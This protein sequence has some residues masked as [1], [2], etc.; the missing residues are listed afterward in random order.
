MG[1]ATLILDA[2][3]S[4]LRRAMGEIPGITQRAQAVMTSQAR[5]GGRERV[6]VDQTFAREHEAISMRLRRAR[7]KQEKDATAKAKEEERKRARDA[8]EFARVKDSIHTQLMRER[9]RRE[10]AATRTEAAEGR[11]RLAADVAFN[12]ERDRA[13]AAMV[14]DRQRRE[15]QATRERRAAEREGGQVVGRIGSAIGGAATGFATGMD[16]QVQSARQR[17]AAPER[18]VGNAIY[19]AGGDRSETAAAMR[20]ITEFAQANRIPAEEIAQ[21]LQGAQTE[22]SVLGSRGQGNAGTRDTALSAFLNTA[23]LAR[24]TGNDVGETTRLAG[25][26]ASQG[27]DPALRQQM[28]LYTAGATQRGAVEIGDVTRGAMPAITA[29][30]GAAMSSA[31]L[32]PGSNAASIQAAGLA[33]YRQALAEIEVAKGTQG[34]SP[35]EAGNAMR[36][37]STALQSSV[38]QEKLLNNIRTSL[39]DN[40][41]IERAL[42]EAD[43]ARPGRPGH[44]GGMRLRAPMTNALNLVGAF[45][46]AGMTS[47]Q[48]QNITGGGGAGNPLSILANQRRLLGGLLDTDAGGTSGAARVRELMNPNVG[49]TQADVARGAGIFGN[50]TMAQLVGNEEANTNALRDLHPDLVSV[51]DSINNWKMRNPWLATGTQAGGGAM[52]DIA[53]TLGGA[54][55]GGGGVAAALRPGAMAGARALLG[56]G[57]A[58]LGAMGSGA[59]RAAA[60]APMLLGSLLT[61]G[62]SYG[63]VDQEEAVA[64]RRGGLEYERQS[65][66]LGA[67]AQAEHRPPPTA[68]EIGAAVAIALRGAPLAVTPDQHANA[69]AASA[70]PPQARR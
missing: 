48:F 61:L 36:N 28:L 60:G 44:P 18:A 45:E 16:G 50:D 52:S 17:R 39:G 54:A 7:E 70:A 51:S 66:L 63:G 33:E 57:T 32:A 56:R 68:A 34:A 2:D 47:T 59:L 31:R 14:R 58:A 3:V 12:R 62:G 43:P 5:R 64:Q 38:T 21:A 30:M 1:R 67:Q 69:H 6:S 8:G 20:R 29:R 4:A 26:F 42:Y 25:L 37:V 24:N 40:S 10:K 35:R 22:Q 27:I 13:H 46:Q 55:T 65:R 49:L 9:D 41:A 15:R 53:K 23:L 11:K 19:Q